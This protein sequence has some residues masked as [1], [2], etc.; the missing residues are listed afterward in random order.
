VVELSPDRNEIALAVAGDQR[1]R[2]IQARRRDVRWL[3]VGSGKRCPEEN[4]E[5]D[6]ERDLWH[7][8]RL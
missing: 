7:G 3:Q 6:E 2:C 8:G 1:P 4:T 5:Q